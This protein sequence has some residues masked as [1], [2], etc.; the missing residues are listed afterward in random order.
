MRFLLAITT[1]TLGLLFVLTT[2]NVGADDSVATPEIAGEIRV[3]PPAVTL[4]HRRQPQS[5]LVTATSPDGYSVDLTPTTTFSTAEANIATVDAAG[6]VTPVA[7]GS[8]VVTVSSAGQT[9]QIAVQVELP[10]AERPFSFRHEVMPALSKAGCNMGACHG[11]SLGKNGFKLSLRGSDPQLDLP[12]ITKENF[13]RR[14]DS[15]T[16]EASILV[17]K[18]TGDVP[19]EGGIRFR[20]GSLQRE[21][22]IRWITQGTPSD[23]EDTARVVRVRV[24]PERLMLKPGQTHQLQLVAEYNDGTTRDVTRHA[25]FTANNDQHATIGDNGL[26]TGGEFGETAIVGRFERKFAAT[27]A[28]VLRPATDFQPAPLSGDHFVDR[29][30]NTKLNELKVTPS[31]PA[32]DAQFLRRVYLDLIG[33]QP[34]PNEIRAFLAD[35][36]VDK[37]TRVIDELFL[38]P[39]FV[40]HWSLKWGDLLQNSRLSTGSPSVYLFREWIR[41]AVASNMP[42]DEFTRQLLTANGGVQDDPASVYLAGSKDTNDTLER[43]TQVF[44]GI[45]M[46]CARCHPHPMENWTQADY[47]GIGSFFNQIST[48]QDPRF[49]TVAKTKVL[50]VNLAAGFAGNPRTGQPQPPRF[51]GGEEPAMEPGIDRRQAYAQWL[52]S[53]ENP[54]FA[55][56]LTNRIWSY[57]FSRGIVEPVDDVRSTNP[58]I[59]PELLAALTDDFIASG[60]DMRH[61][62]RRI[63]TSQTYQRSSTPLPSNEFDLQNFSHALPRRVPA[64][65]LMDSLIQATGVPENFRG[66]PAGF[67][68][69]QLPDGNIDNDLLSLFGKPQRMDACECERDN[70]SNMLQALH[71]INSES[72]S[73]RLSN[74]GGRVA[75][76]LKESKDDDA[77]ITDLYLWTLARM[78]DEQELA[79]AKDYLAQRTDRRQEACED[80]MWALLNSR[81]FQ[82]VN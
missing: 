34:T 43:V 52:T 16:P 3:T 77:L 76:L 58:P 60:F 40:D 41:G 39:E 50:S 1:I 55:R 51:L 57:F 21:I 28:I 31:G 33:V 81:D 12:A 15:V 54:L 27:G 30:V 61:L 38:R 62:M 48:R 45:R 32:P 68:A 64:E 20:R 7:T 18:P 70:S 8:T 6:W 63:V 26:V 80:L 67:R 19:H 9:R 13:G 4:R 66:A 69:A 11:Y 47:Y 23:L 42:L 37:R 59:N 24:H 29:L 56:G 49:R 78:P 10:E 65:S 74:G 22:L 2:G 71:F 79:V 73:A 36:S 46:L 5:L 17:S 75:R 72:M 82:L 14:L 25:V 35:G 44:C 53:A